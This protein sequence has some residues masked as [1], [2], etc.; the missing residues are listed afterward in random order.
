MRFS[1]QGFDCHFCECGVRKYNNLFNF[2]NPG[3][4]KPHSAWLRIKRLYYMGKKSTQSTTK[5]R[6][7][8][9]G[10]YVTKEYAQKHPATTVKE[11]DKKKK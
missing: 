1:T 3:D 7:A 11:T 9:D 5:Y 10:Q 6:D 2:Q 4:T 8:K